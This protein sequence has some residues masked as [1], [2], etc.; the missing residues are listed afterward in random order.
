M[1]TPSMWT[2]FE[3]GTT[4]LEMLG[5]W[6]EQLI[7]IEVPSGDCISTVQ[8]VVFVM[9]GGQIGI[10]LCVICVLVT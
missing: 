10:Q 8:Q 1:V 2:D 6:V 9:V 3:H 7:V 5:W 4:V